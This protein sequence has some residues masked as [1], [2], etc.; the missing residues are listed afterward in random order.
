LK[1]VH[2]SSAAFG[3]ADTCKP[4]QASPSITLPRHTE[5]LR[6]R[7]LA[8]IPR[9]WARQT[10]QEQKD[11]RAP[12]IIGASRYTVKPPLPANNLR[13]PSRK[14]R[15]RPPRKNNLRGHTY[16]FCKS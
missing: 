15:Q 6:E 16:D 11:T 2:P 7:I 13:R 4:G 12:P 10:G 3:D 1:I 8:A 5:S 14:K 9:F